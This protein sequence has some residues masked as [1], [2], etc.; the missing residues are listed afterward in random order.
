MPSWFS[1]I[2]EVIPDEVFMLTEDD[3]RKRCN[4]TA[5]EE[6]LRVSFWQEYYRVSQSKKIQQIN[7]S[8]VCGGICDNRTFQ[9][10]I[11]N[12]FT[13]AF[14]L[15]APPEINTSLEDILLLG[16]QRMRDIMK[17]PPVDKD[18]CFDKGIADIQLKIYQDALNRRRGP[19]KNTHELAS[20]SMHLHKHLI[21]NATLPPER[22]ATAIDIEAHLALEEPPAHITEMIE[23]VQKEEV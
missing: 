15:M 8:N 5:R 3:L 6:K 2:L 17:L 1:K 21:E 10:L 7:I 4:P 22:S 9:A 23:H 11:R 13:L 12:S 14:V 20:K 19:V 16:I 18:G